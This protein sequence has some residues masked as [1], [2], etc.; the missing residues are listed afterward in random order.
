MF[1]TK[2]KLT[3]AVVLALGVTGAGTGVALRPTAAAGD[4]RLAQAAPPKAAAPPVPVKSDVDRT[5]D[6]IKQARDTLKGDLDQ[7]EK[8]YLEFRQQK[9]FPR[10]WWG[11]V[12]KGV[13]ALQTTLDQFAVRRI[14]LNAQI[15]ALEGAIR[16][17]GDASVLLLVIQR[18]GTPTGTL[19]DAL[20]EERR[21]RASAADLVQL[22][23]AALKQELKLLDVQEA[24]VRK[25]TD[26]RFKV[27]QQLNSYEAKEDQLKSNVTT[28]KELYAVLVR[29]LAEINVQR[30]QQRQNP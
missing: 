28:C 18:N 13:A 8:A 23:V 15:E 21:A 10:E 7:A 6:L 25:L 16:S 19:R 12:Q 29:K 26:E 22:H 11:E 4:E 30:D 1:L 17:G 20:P 2:L 9:P 14:E 24:S 3:A 27:L 5:L